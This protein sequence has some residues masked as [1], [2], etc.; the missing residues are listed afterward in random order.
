VEEGGIKSTTSPL[1]LLPHYLAK[2]KW[3]A[4]HLYFHIHE[5]NML[6]VSRHLFHEFMFV[7]LSVL[8]DTDVVMTLVEYF[9]SC[10]TQL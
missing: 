8:P 5:N 7:N 9:V 6:H 2:R 4:V 10:I 1:N 3:S